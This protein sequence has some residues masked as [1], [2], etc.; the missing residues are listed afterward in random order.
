[1]SDN[2]G[3]AG[4]DGLL[5]GMRAFRRGLDLARPV[6]RDVVEQCLSVALCAPSGANRQPWRF[7]LVDDVATK[8]RLA[9]HYRK[10]AE[11]YLTDRPPPPERQRDVAS[12]RFLAD[13]LHEVPVLVLASR[14]GRPPAGAASLSSFYGSI[15]PVIWSFMLAARG[16]GLGSCLT[17]VHLC[18]EREIAALLG[19]PCDE[20]TQVALIPVGYLRGEPV[21][22]PVRRPVAAVATWNRWGAGE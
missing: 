3:P 11:A 21:R 12:A 1:V 15:Y 18:Y 13:R 20:V 14:L 4:I 22:R 6:P 19:M 10:A 8:C 17:T 5:T 7:V 9:V 2:E 16:R